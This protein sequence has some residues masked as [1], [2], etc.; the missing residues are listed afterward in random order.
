MAHL[1]KVKAGDPFKIPAP[2]YNAMIDAAKAHRQS[3]INFE[4]ETDCISDQSTIFPLRNNSGSDLNRF[5]ILGIGEPIFDPEFHLASF[6]NDIAFD[7]SIP[8]KDYIGKFAILQGPANAGKIAKACYSGTSVVRIDVI[9]ERHGF[10][11]AKIDET[12]H[13]ESRSAGSAQIL[14]KAPGTGISWA[15]VRLGTRARENVFWAG[16]TKVTR[17]RA[18][19]WDYDFEEVEYLYDIWAPFGPCWRWFPITKKGYPVRAGTARNT[20]E[21]NQGYGNP[22]GNGVNRIINL[23]AAVWPAAGVDPSTNEP[24][25]YKAVVRMHEL[26]EGDHRYWFWMN[27]VVTIERTWTCDN[28]ENCTT[29]DFK[30]ACTTGDI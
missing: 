20:V 23:G 7:G 16:I 27:N 4:T 15:I 17:V 14:W 24:P 28:L 29:G 11:E 21:I 8:T 6:K 18:H 2:D 3:L 13:L 9:D 30:C 25:F 22:L 12:D 10:A 26:P 1:K 5:S 19:V